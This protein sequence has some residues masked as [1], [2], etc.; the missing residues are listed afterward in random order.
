MAVHVNKDK[1]ITCVGCVGVCPQNAL[2]YVGTAIVVDEKE[3]NE[4]GICV[5]F[6]PMAALA[7]SRKEGKK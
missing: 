1:C 3:C 7:L 6:C 5:R 2:D 4:C